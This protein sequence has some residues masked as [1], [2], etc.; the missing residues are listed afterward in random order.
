MYAN[1][2]QALWPDMVMKIM[3]QRDT[4]D[5]AWSR[6]PGQMMVDFLNLFPPLLR[7]S[8][9]PGRM[10]R[11]ISPTMDLCALAAD[12]YNGSEKLFYSHMPKAWDENASVESLSHE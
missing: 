3:M 9:R 6:G 11:S 2:E 4:Y 1:E 8:G 5:T 10:R 7:T 12:V